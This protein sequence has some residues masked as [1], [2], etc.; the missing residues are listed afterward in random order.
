MTRSNTGH[1]QMPTALTEAWRRARRLQPTAEQ[2]KPLARTAAAAARQQADKTR[3]WAA[4]QVERAG[5][6][7]QDNIAPKASSLLS[8]AA[9]RIDPAR[10]PA[11]PRRPWGKLAGAS[12][13]A[14]GASAAAAFAAAVRRRMKSAA[15]E[16]K[17]QPAEAPDTAPG[18]EAAPAAETNNG[19]AT[20]PGAESAAASETAPAAD[21]A[22][23]AETHNGQRG[24]DSDVQHGGLPRTS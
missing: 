14:A 4:P 22:P 7:L 18:A 5:Q 3:A 16:A 9:H 8:S 24:A 17:D 10:D 23:G 13:A 11:R 19:A 21:S 1:H 12:A 6:V 2:V 15:A 20:A